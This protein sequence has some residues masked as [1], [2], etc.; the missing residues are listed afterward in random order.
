MRWAAA[1]AAA[2]GLA[3]GLPQLLAWQRSQEQESQS[4]GNIRRVAVALLSYAQDWDDRLPPIAA[5]RG[6]GS[7]T[8]WPEAVAGYESAR[9]SFV[10]P[11]NPVPLSGPACTN[12][13]DHYAVRT[14]F[15]LNARFWN[16]FGPGPFPVGNVELPEQTALLIDAGPLSREPREPASRASDRSRFAFL[17]YGD[18]TDRYNGL[19]RYPSPHSG[20]I[21]VIGL[22]GH[23]VSRR[24]AHYSPSDGP[25]DRLYGLL[26]PGIYNWNGGHPN[27]QTDRPRR[28]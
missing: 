20:L 24:V 7:W 1:I 11:A 9:S 26:V 14:S 17:D 2:I 5:R 18:T 21:T 13:I 3:I 10:D 28:Q 15:A 25:H 4:V 23:A 27:G 12:P 22:D 16:T 6:S 8:T 19:F